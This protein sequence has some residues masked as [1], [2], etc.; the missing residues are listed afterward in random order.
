MQSSTRT[1]RRAVLSGAAAV[2]STAAVAAP[3]DREDDTKLI[4]LGRQLD[5]A[6]AQWSQLARTEDADQAALEH[7]IFRITGVK[8]KDAPRSRPIVGTGVRKDAE[9][10]WQMRDDII[11]CTPARYSDDELGDLLKQIDARALPLCAAIAAAPARTI[12]GLAV[13]ARALQYLRADVWRSRPLDDDALD[14]EERL[15]TQF[16]EDVC[17][18]AGVGSLVAET[19]FFDP[20]EI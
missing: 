1:S 19:G 14:Q 3:A 15:Q 20:S 2:A 16:Y 13:K 5:V 4:E 9:P 17:S 10:Y 18:V 7:E 8:F 11:A 6:L 12:A